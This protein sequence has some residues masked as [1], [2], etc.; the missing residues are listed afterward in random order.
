VSLN[1]N[2]PCIK[3]SPLKL[4]PTIDCKTLPKLASRMARLPLEMNK[5]LS[6]LYGY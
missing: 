1:D 5:L 2:E 6:N 3:L 4:N